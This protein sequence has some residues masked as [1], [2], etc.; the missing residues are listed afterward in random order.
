MEDERESVDRFARYKDIKFYELAFLV[1][2]KMVIERGVALRDRFEAVVKVENDLVQRQLV[3]EHHAVFGHVL[4]LFLNAAF[5][6]EQGKDTAKEIIVREDR[7]LDV[8]L[9]DLRYP[10]G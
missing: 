6:I 8:R 1:S 4:E 2:G 9:L 3:N 5:F 7:R 10:A